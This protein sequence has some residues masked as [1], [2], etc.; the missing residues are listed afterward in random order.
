MRL[1]YEIAGVDIAD[2]VF[3]IYPYTTWKMLNDTIGF[4]T[5]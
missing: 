3:K 5:R 1:E 2:R 4:K